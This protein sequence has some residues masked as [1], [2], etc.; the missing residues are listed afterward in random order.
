MRFPQTP[1]RIFVKKNNLCG[2][3]ESMCVM[4]ATGSF[5]V[6]FEMT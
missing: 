2:R 6:K 1:S 5:Y 3:G 4:C